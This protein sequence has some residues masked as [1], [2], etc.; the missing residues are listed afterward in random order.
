MDS[1]GLLR[2]LRF[3]LGQRDRELGVVL[4]ERGSGIGAARSGGMTTNL[5]LWSRLVQLR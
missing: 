1:L 2:K 3:L 4:G 5:F